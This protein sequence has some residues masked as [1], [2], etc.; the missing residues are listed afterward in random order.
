[1]KLLADLTLPR[2]E[3]LTVQADNLALMR[4][5]VRRS[6]TCTALHPYEGSLT[7]EGLPQ[8][9]LTSRDRLAEWSAD[10]GTPNRITEGDIRLVLRSSGSSGRVRTLLHDRL[11]N[12]RVEAIGARGLCLDG[13]GSNPFVLNSLA[14]GD[15][16]G[17]FGFAD[18]VLSRRG[19]AV[20][21]AGTSMPAHHLAELIT[22]LDVA[23]MVGLP[24]YI[25][26]LLTEI[27]AEMRKLRT[28]YYLGE[29]MASPAAEALAAAGCAVRSFAY[30]TTETGPIGF[31]CGHLTGTDHHVHEDLVIA[32]VVDDDGRRLPDGVPGM[33]AVTVLAASGT[34]LV[35][36]LVGDRAS[37]RPSECPCGSTARVLRIGARDDVSANLTGT[38]VTRSMFDTALGLRPDARYQVE[39]GSRGGMLRLT[40]RG[41]AL[42]D[43]TDEAALSSLGRHQTLRKVVGSSVFAGLTVDA[44][45]APRITA[46]AKAPFFWSEEDRDDH[47]QD[48]RD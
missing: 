11:F 44:G 4:D 40:L 27:P 25:E 12:E 47:A 19:A 45:T 24:G 14:P 46:R 23:A 22:D 36:Y 48:R 8:V 28:L 34:A 30:S 5:A 21:P 7:P 2:S 42:H 43:L 20:L 10:P 16:F 18:A 6:R 1:M 35:R 15:L 38:L 33:L 26:R 3:L 31:Q 32:E 29:R 37:L 17:G 41:A 13:L 9:P 39:Y